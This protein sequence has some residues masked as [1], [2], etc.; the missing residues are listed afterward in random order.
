MNKPRGET[1]LCR[2]RLIKYCKG[3]GLDLGCGNI[4]IKSDAIGI[5]LTNPNA[6]MRQDVRLMPYY[7][8]EH[9]D[10][11][12][13]SH[14]LEEIEDTESTLKEWIRVI[15]PGGFLVLYQ[16]DKEYYYPLNDPRCNKSH[17]HHFSLE[18]LKDILLKTNMVDIIHEGR[19]DPDTHKE[20]SFEIVAQ[21]KGG[22]TYKEAPHTTKFKFLIVGG[23]AE[24][25]IERCLQSIVDQD[26]PYWKAQVV[27]DPVDGSYERAL[28]FKSNKIDIIKNL[29]RKYNI[30]NFIKAMSL[31]ELEDEDVLVMV[32]ADDWL[33]NS[34]VL[35]TLNSY[36][37]R[38]PDLLLTHGSWEP[39]PNPN[40]TNN[41]AYSKE[42]FDKGI[43]NVRWRGSHL[44]TCKYKLWKYLRDETLRDGDYYFTVAGDLAIMFPLLEMAGYNRVQFIPDILYIYNQESAFN[45]EKK[46]LQEQKQNEAKLR[47]MAPY[48]ILEEEM[49]IEN[50]DYKE[51]KENSKINCL[52]YS[53]NR[54]C[55]LD[56]FLRSLKLHWSNWKEETKITVIWDYDNDVYLAGY[57]KLLEEHPNINFV[58]QHNK[59]FKQMITEEIDANLPY[60][61]QFVDDII[62]TNNFSLN[63]L[64]FKSFTEDEECICL[65][66]RM[67]PGITYCYMT[68]MNTTPPDSASKGRWAWSNQSGDWGY[69]ASVDGHI[70]KTEDILPCLLN[71]KYSQ[72]NS[73]EERMI[74]GIPFKPYMRCFQE[75]R[76]INIPAN[77][78]GVNKSNK[79]GDISAELLNEK[80]LNGSRI[81]IKPFIG[82]K[83]PSVHFEMEYEWK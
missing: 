68:D 82:L 80:Y 83:A 81:N 4:K 15:K 7:D 25:Y 58:N 10:Y 9:F 26:Y 37:A 59:D 11:I 60:T 49:Q 19:Y 61:I 1:D 42:D 65:S 21:K 78:V 35:S 17:I 75:A 38:Q 12:Y 47:R 45:D 16:V 57:E 28:K 18:E 71:E 66:L 5:D 53:K 23:Y 46:H 77:K 32:D 50:A 79:C 3:Q 48:K 34:S 62:F 22:E 36:Y 73:L 63:A 69:P 2:S 33:A 67:H 14:L 56:T 39:Y 24:N 55:Q 6:D 13:S 64:E 70:F 74:R 41:F 52:V 44:R 8:N 43:R 72:P 29:E 54:A 51:I 27:L 30:A 40:R 31:L 20:W 76:I